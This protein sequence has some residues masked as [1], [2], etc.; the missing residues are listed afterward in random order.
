MHAD[1]GGYFHCH[2]GLVYPEYGG[3]YLGKTNES[4]LS[5]AHLPHLMSPQ[6]YGRPPLHVP[7]Q[8]TKWVSNHVY[9]RDDLEGDIYEPGTN[10]TWPLLEA[11]AREM[12]DKQAQVTPTPVIAAAV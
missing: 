2:D 4:C 9:H 10:W 7:V 5:F 8:Q 11:R 1:A 12:Q 6:R 3:Q